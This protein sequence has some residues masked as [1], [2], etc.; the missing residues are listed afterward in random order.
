M[1]LLN[2]SH[3]VWDLP[4]R[5]FHWVLAIAFVTSWA[6]HE[7]AAIEVHRWSG[8][9]TLIL[10]CFRIS[11]GVFGSTHS[12]FTNFV[13]G[14]KAVLTY[15][16]SGAKPHVGHNPAGGWSILAMLLLILAQTLTGLFNSDELLF[17]GPFFHALDSDWADRIGGLHETIFEV[18]SVLIGLHVLVVLYYKYRRKID[19]IKPMITGGEDMKAQQVPIWWAVTALGFW[20]VALYTA[21]Y[22]APAPKLPW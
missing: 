6:S 12:R 16:R 3:P 9:T 1:T 17:D 5:L 4:T 11:W 15:F 7:L 20:S 2:A 13:T 19:L 21:I 10:V 14:P 22:F 18:L 8:Y